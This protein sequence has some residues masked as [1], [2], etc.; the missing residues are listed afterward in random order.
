MVCPFSAVSLTDAEQCINGGWIARTC[1]RR[2]LLFLLSPLIMLIGGAS[3]GIIP[4]SVA[5]LTAGWAVAL[6]RFGFGFGAC[7]SCYG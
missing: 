5:D 6:N 4:P 1:A 7:V 2:A 3:S